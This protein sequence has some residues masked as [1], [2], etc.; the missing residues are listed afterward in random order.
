M[1]LSTDPPL[2]VH[3]VCGV[4]DSLDEKLMEVLPGGA[5]P[6]EADLAEIVKLEPIAHAL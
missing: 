4:L 3:A 5:S 2:A 6:T 1:I